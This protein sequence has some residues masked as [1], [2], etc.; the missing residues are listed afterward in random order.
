MLNDKYSS[1]EITKSKKI[2]RHDLDWLRIILFGLLIPFHVSIGIY[3]TTY[4]E[5][6][7]P[8]LENSERS[9]FLDYSEDEQ[10]AAINLYTQESVDPTSM[11]LH[12]M[13]QWRLAALFMISGFG[14][15]FAFN[16]R[17]WQQFTKERF[18]RLLVP[19]IFGVWTVGFVGSI[20]LGN[21]ETDVD[22]LVSGF[23]WGILL[24]LFFWVPILGKI[25]SLGHLWFVWNLFLY[26][27]LL[28]PIFHYINKKPDRKFSKLIKSPFY[29]PNG[30]GVFLIF[31]SILTIIEIIFKP[32][33]VGFLGSGYQWFWYFLFFLFGYLCI[34]CKERYYQILEQ[35]RIPISISTAILTLAFIWIRIQ[36][37][38]SGIPYV[39]GGWVSFEIIHD[40]KTILACLVHSFHSW[41]WCLTIFSWGAHFLNHPSNR[42][43]YLNQG[44]YT[45]YIIHMPLTF[46]SLHLSSEI[47][48]TGFFAVIFS[49]IFVS[50]NCLLFFEIVRRNKI[51]RLLFGIKEMKNV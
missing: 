10:D 6:I 17:N 25:L 22:G 12:W 32:W 2:R 8:N 5:Q 28:T 29:L 36:Q 51:S 47:G 49:T 44:V 9:G 11:F 26:S 23:L 40:S 33:M 15:A 48:I 39:D 21:I 7:N 13:H 30:L 31:P 24:S 35:W 42:L 41:F 18:I 20:I 38:D 16:N 43:R 14:T 37:H 4:G 45:F 50:I 3:W 1:K 46:F 19:M 34:I 27:I